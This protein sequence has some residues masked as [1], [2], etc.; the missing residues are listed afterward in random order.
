MS[1]Y[2][3]YVLSTN[4]LQLPKEYD[5]EKAI[6]LLLYH[7]IMLNPGDNTLYPEMGVGLTTKWRYMKKDDLSSLS[8]CIKKQIQ[9]YLPQLQAVNVELETNNVNNSLTI[10]ISTDDTMYSFDTNEL[11]TPI[12]LS[13]FN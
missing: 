2:K 3:E 9:L 13:D 7:L 5:D 6:G 8:T 4:N 1:T 12:T 10:G 11:E